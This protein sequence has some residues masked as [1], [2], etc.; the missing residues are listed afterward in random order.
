MAKAKKSRD[1]KTYYKKVRDKNKS[2]PDAL[3]TALIRQ[4]Y[5]IAGEHS[6]AKLCLW[7][8]KSLKGQ[9]K[10][11]KNQFY[12]IESHRCLQCT[13]VLLFCNHACVFCWRMMPEKSLK[14]DEIPK[15]GFSWDR[16]EKVVS[17][18][19][20]SQKRIVSGFGGNKKVSKELFKEALRPKHAAISLTGEPAMYPYLEGLFKEFHKR[21]MTTFLVT[22]G[23]FPERMEKW[24]TLPTQLY[25]SMVAPNEKVYRK[26]IRPLS[27]NLWKKYLKTLALLPKIG[28]K[29]R[30]VLR[31]TLAREV[32]DFDL[33]GYAEQIKI[34][35]PHYV[36]VKSMAFVGGARLQERG[37]STKS[38]LEMEEVGVIAKKLAQMSGYRASDVHAPSRI[39][40]LCRDEKAEKNRMIKWQ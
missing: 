24:E 40:L 22:N 7:A 20:E 5:H 27:N 3:L 35:K 30:T 37:L 8:G 16:P 2:I 39:V 14:F 13:P 28:E 15:K 4:K 36:E 17:L 23:T 29:T 6:A 33:D 32:N 9:G 10:C 11:Y 26:S 25:V 19:L 21:G 18:L 31:M 1:R 34:A 38:M 12:G